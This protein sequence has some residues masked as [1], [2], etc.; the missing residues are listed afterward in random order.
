LAE[1][2]VLKVGGHPKGTIPSQSVTE[3]VSTMNDEEIRGAIIGMVLGDGSLPMNGRSIN[4]HMDYA[5]CIKQREYAVW[6]SSI[7]EKLTSVRVTDGVSRARGKEYPKVRVISK[8]HPTYTH[9]WKRFYHNGRKTVDS[10]LMDHL[11]P[12]GLAIWY[13]D[14]GHLKN[15]EDYLTPILETNSFNVAEHMI[16]TKALAD[17]FHLEFRANSLN[18]KY[19]MLRL[20]RK[21]R[22]RFFDIIREHIHPTMD[23]KIRDDGKAVMLTGDPIKSN[24]EICGEGIVKAFTL[25][26]DKTRGRFC[27]RC[28]D[29]HRSAIGTTRNQYSESRDSQIPLAIMGAC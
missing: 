15:H 23:Y 25:R 4:A 1:L 3:G 21:D 26:N 12:L 8:T 6:K 28:Y 22:E 9:L 7:L 20:R 13:Q 24:C 18:A 2:K 16:M 11:T 29:S 17:K 5:H 14:D 27:R 10:F 19:L